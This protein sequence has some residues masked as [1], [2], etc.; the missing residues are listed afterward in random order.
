MDF[1]LTVDQINE[2]IDQNEWGKL[3]EYLA[4]A[5][6]VDIA[7]LLEELDNDKMLLVFRILPKDISADVFSYMDPD[8]QAHVVASIS[9]HEVRTLIDHLFLDD[10]VDFLEE[11]PA[12]V[13]TKVLQNTNEATRKLINQFLNYPDNSA[14]SIMTIEFI[15]FRLGWTVRHAMDHLRA[16]ATDSEMISTCFVTNEKR[17]LEGIVELRQLILAE[18]D[19][20]IDSIME[21]TPLCVHTLDDQEFVA[22][23][24]QKYDLM[25]VP[26][27]DN[28]GRLV[29]IITIDDIVDVVQ[30]E[31]T[32]DFEKMAAMQPSEDE[33]LKTSVFSMAKHRI[34]WLLVLML[35]ATFTGRIIQ[36]YNDL[37][38]NAI[39]LASFYPM[40]MDTGGNCGS[41][42]STLIIRGMALGEIQWRDLFRVQW[43]ELRVGFLVGA[44]LAVVNFLR[45]TLL[46]RA[47]VTV[48]IVVSVSLF[49]TVVLAKFIGCTMPMLAKK[50]KLDPALMASPI[51]TTIV[52][53]CALALYFF[54]ASHL[55]NLA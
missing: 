40:L 54:I 5:N 32:E 44:I 26:V 16:N 20:I 39:I 36:H 34:V 43:K 47:G 46:E 8:Q 31:N 4:E 9:N 11:M 42:A 48:A 2:L 30:E 19:A 29:G 51:I 52:D 24:A 17:Q 21:D 49:C 25:S 13:V 45:V 15:Q 35:S 41:Q 27:T 7:A 1:N 38:Q 55:M 18:D 3:R 12:N 6:E 50:V 14:G 22:A 28:E 53:A 10:T 33:Y 37:L 23:Q